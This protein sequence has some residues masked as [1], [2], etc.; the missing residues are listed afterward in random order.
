MAL[1]SYGPRLSTDEARSY[2]LCTRA[3]LA[4]ARL[5]QLLFSAFDKARPRLRPLLFGEAAT[6]ALD[7]FLAQCRKAWLYNRLYIG[8]ADGMSVARVWT[9]R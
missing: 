7:P 1:Y 8:V 3:H 6:A 4:S 2:V 5:V 9:C